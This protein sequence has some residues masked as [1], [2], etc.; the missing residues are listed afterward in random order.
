MIAGGLK[1][2]REKLCGAGQGSGTQRK[3]QKLASSRQH[4]KYN[5]ATLQPEVTHRWPDAFSGCTFTTPNCR[6]ATSRCAAMIHKKLIDP[7]G[8]ATLGRSE[9]HTSELQSRFGTSHAV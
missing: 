5:I 9:E 7:P 6:S 1:P 4:V 3:I 2:R 8:A